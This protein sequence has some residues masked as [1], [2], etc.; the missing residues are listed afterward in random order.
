VTALDDCLGARQIDAVSEQRSG[1]LVFD[2]G[3]LFGELVDLRVARV[4]AVPA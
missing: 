4:W 1:Y 2:L 3:S